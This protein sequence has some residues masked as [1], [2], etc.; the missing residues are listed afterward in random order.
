MLGPQRSLDSTLWDF[1]LWGYIR[2]RM[3]ILPM[4]SKITD[5]RKRIVTM[6]NT[7]VESIELLALTPNFK[8]IFN[9]VLPS[10]PRPS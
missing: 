5:E 1:F 9:T 4:S 3:F 2:D 8:D 6:L 10:N 7:R